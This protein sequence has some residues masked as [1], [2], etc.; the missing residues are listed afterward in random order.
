MSVR[1][2]HFSDY[3]HTFSSQNTYL[4]NP[5]L[6]RQ[7]HTVLEIYHGEAFRKT[8]QDTVILSVPASAKDVVLLLHV[9]I[10]CL[11]PFIFSSDLFKFS[12]HV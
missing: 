5:E 10:S 11:V 4:L 6:A 12:L 7:F 8:S 3:C 1:V 2:V 9:F